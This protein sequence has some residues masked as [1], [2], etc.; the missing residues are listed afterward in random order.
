VLARFFRLEIE[1][2][3][4][5]REFRFLQRAHIC[6]AAGVGAHSALI[7]RIRRRGTIKEECKV[8]SSL[9]CVSH[10]AN[11]DFQI[12]RATVMPYAF[13]FE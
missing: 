1:L 6:E 13:E 9:F 2:W 3:A 11:L 10:N 7:V 8:L 12:D 5:A 4:L